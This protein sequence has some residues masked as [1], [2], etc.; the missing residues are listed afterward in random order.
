MKKLYSKPIVESEELLEQTSLQCSATEENVGNNFA[1]A[2]EDGGNDVSKGG[3]MDASCN[4]PT[5]EA[6]CIVVLS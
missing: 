1:P 3:L 6:A 4:A 5:Y 2:C